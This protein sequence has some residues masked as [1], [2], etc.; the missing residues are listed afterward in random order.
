MVPFTGFRVRE[1]EM[2]ALGM[3]LPGLAHRAAAVAQLPALGLLTLAGLTP[4]HWT[5]SYHEADHASASLADEIARQHPTLVAL[6]A[7]TASVEEAY[8][9]S[10]LL[11]GRGMRVVIGGLHVTT[12][13]EEAGRYCDAVVIGEGEPVWPAVLA[14]AEAGELRP[15]YRASAPFDL[16]R[17]PVPRFDLLGRGPRPRL[18]VQTQRGCPLACEFCGASRL[19][20]PHRLKPV[21]NLKRELA[22]ITAQ[23]PR[24]VLELAD[25]NTFA[26]GRNSHELLE[27][28]AAADARYFTE[29][30]W[31]VGEDPGL[32][33][34]LA[35]SGCV[36]VLIGI[37]S[38]VFRHPG[39]G[40]KQA[41]LPRIMTA[42]DAIQSAGVAVIGC[43]IVGCDGETFDSLDRL[44]AFIE[45]SSLAD[46]QLTLQTPFPG[47]PLRRRLEREG[48]LLPGRGW[49]HCTLF[50]LTFRPDLMGIEEMELAFR[51]LARRVFSPAQ[52]VR[53]QAIRKRV[54]HNNP[55]LRPCASEPSSSS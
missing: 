50:D 22:A 39:M 16:A 31:R 14:D 55:R 47:T 54:W 19:L 8:R 42:I 15:V 18:T 29:V 37:E 1:E 36:Q 7:L 25:D 3:T 46:V 26:G 9:F 38:L 32:L 6:S 34:G 30:D 45:A 44:A 27:T 23:V 33:A 10:G 28:L 5:C 13:P 21:A 43:F 12:C 11:R 40:P 4:P 35:A 49:S 53:R 48:R 24:P 17:A 51:D 2:L 20:G 52:S 41:E